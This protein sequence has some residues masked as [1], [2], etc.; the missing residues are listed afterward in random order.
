MPD[1]VR[2]KLAAPISKKKESFQAKAVQT[3][4]QTVTDPAQI[5]G[6]RRCRTFS[7]GSPITFVRL[8]RIS[9]TKRAAKP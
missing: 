6:L 9:A 7:K 4:A 2:K 3:F 8:P 1:R 5:I